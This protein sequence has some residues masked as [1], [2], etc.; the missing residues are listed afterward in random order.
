MFLS[1]AMSFVS[2]K[3]FISFLIT[4]FQLIFG[5]PLSQNFCHMLMCIS[6]HISYTNGWWT[7][8]RTNVR[9]C[10]LC[11]CGNLSGNWLFP[12]LKFPMLMRVCMHFSCTKC[13]CVPWRTN[14]CFCISYMLPWRCIWWAWTCMLE[15]VLAWCKHTPHCYSSNHGFKMQF[16]S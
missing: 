4:A 10:I 16:W 2:P 7:P 12:C 13:D 14:I 15:W 9:F 1:C 6:V 11:M 5:R 8:R 3:L